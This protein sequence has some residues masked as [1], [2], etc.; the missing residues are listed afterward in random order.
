MKFVVDANVIGLHGRDVRIGILRYPWNYQD[1]IR[2]IA[3]RYGI[4]A[5]WPFYFAVGRLYRDPDTG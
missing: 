2:R 5:F 4:R 3:K 1:A